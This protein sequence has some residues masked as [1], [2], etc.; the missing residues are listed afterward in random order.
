MAGVDRRTAAHRW[1]PGG[2]ARPFSPTRSTKPIVCF[3]AW[4]QPME[5]TH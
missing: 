5:A 4:I 3:A 2:R 1:R